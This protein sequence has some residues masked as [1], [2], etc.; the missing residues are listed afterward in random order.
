MENGITEWKSIELVDKGWSD[1]K[2]YKVLTNNNEELLLKV[3]DISK[4]T[5]K[6]AE[7]E[8]IKSLE[9]KKILMPKAIDIGV[10]QEKEIVYTVYTWLSGEDAEGKIKQFSS[11]MQ[12]E[13]GLTAGMYLKEIHSISAP[14]SVE[15]WEIR[16]NRKIDTKI[17]RYKECGIEFF[18]AEK[19]INYLNNNRDLLINR[20]QCLQHGDYHI[21]N[22]IITPENKLGII[23]FN[24]FDYG[25]PWEEF[26]RIVW[27]AQASTEFAS[28][29]INGYFNDDVPADFFKLMLLYICSNSLSSVYWAVPFGRE[30]VD[31]MLN[32]IR[33]IQQWYNGLENYIPN[34]YHKNYKEKTQH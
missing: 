25:D 15:S 32:Q 30:Q 5:S 18:G 8:V 16:F 11:E 28:G 7:F 2:K 20:P 17:R 9:N 26:N 4:Y 31:I 22:M 24:R 1:D 10:W 29:Y 14:D 3:S 13:L 19:M 33:E 21:N 23:D 27:C 34:W 12:Y 6:R